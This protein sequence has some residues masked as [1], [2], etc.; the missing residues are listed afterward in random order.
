M[1]YLRKRELGTVKN[2]MVPAVQQKISAQNFREVLD[3]MV[4]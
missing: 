3:Q 2:E 1:K 4:G